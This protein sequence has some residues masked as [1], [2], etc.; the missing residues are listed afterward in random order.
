MLHT[1]GR[2]SGRSARTPVAPLSSAGHTVGTPTPSGVTSPMPVMTTRRG[3]TSSGA[4]APE[5]PLLL[6]RCLMQ[7]RK[8][9]HSPYFHS[10]APGRGLCIYLHVIIE[11]SDGSSSLQ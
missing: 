5:P 11:V 4:P 9:V 7:R 2:S 10:K 1:W 6:L 8:R 3:R